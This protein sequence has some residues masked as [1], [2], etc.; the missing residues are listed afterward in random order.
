ML[1]RFRR[2]SRE[3]RL[4]QCDQV[5]F[6]CSAASVARFGRRVATGSNGLP[7]RSASGLVEEPS[8]MLRLVDPILDQ[9]RGCD[10]AILIAKGVGA[11]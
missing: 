5:E 1:H 7:Y 11:S 9:A 4:Y 6:A 10:I 3:H 8:S 2:G